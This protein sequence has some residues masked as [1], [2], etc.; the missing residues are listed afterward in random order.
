M[1]NKIGGDNMY[2]NLIIEA[3]KKNVTQNSIGD[4]CGVTRNAVAKKMNKDGR[5]TIEEAIAIKQT[6]FPE[7][8]LEYLFKRA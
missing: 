4:A 8:T 2:P 5:F 1:H 6:L 7:C 3:T